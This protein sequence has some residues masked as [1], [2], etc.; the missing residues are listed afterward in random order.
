[1]IWCMY[2]LRD[3]CCGKF[4]EHSSPHRVTFFFLMMR[5]FTPYFFSNFL[6]IYLCSDLLRL[7]SLAHRC[8]TPNWGLPLFRCFPCPP[9][10]MSETVGIW[11][12]EL[13]RGVWPVSHPV[14]A[15][16]GAV[17]VDERAWAESAEWKE[18]RAQ[19]GDLEGFGVP[20]ESRPD[21]QRRQRRSQT[22]FYRSYFL[23]FSFLKRHNKQPMENK[24]V[25]A[26][27]YSSFIW[28][29]K[30]FI[31]LMSNM[32]VDGYSPPCDVWGMFAVRAFQKGATSTNWWKTLK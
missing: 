28:S 18:E 1:M 23:S 6:L 11:S 10:W 19:N 12:W 26:F 15:M 8:P 32:Q 3:D 22:L 29:G 17:D 20:Q 24:S 14:Q 21:L 5:T 13:R 30:N 25:K 16:I 7:L 4:T 31:V 2:A 27:L 9:S